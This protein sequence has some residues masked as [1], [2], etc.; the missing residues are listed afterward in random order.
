MCVQVSASVHECPSNNH[1]VPVYIMHEKERAFCMAWHVC[2]HLQLVL[3]MCADSSKHSSP[4]SQPKSKPLHTIR[5]QPFSH[6]AGC[7]HEW[8]GLVVGVARVG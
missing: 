8:E 7:F 4:L 5:T 3:G 1:K 6:S 2:V